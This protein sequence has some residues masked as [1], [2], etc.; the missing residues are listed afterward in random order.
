MAKVSDEIVDDAELIG[1]ATTLSN[2]IAGMPCI[3]TLYLF[4]SRVRGDHRK[5]SD[6]DVHVEFDHAY[7]LESWI[8]E[9]DDEFRQ[10][11][12]RLPGV[13]KLHQDR[14]DAVVPKVKAAAQSPKL[15]VNKVICVV[16][17]PGPFRNIPA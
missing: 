4:G 13:L 12:S 6:V 11:N 17:P 16:L 2:W 15:V 8:Q 14:T 9:N 7:S 10:I 5:D 1:L 3:E